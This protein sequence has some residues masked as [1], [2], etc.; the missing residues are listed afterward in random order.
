MSI[1][2]AAHR[3]RAMD[4]TL[5]GPTSLAN[6]R[7]VW[8]GR[9]ISGLAIAFLAFDAAM[10]LVAIAPVVEATT[11]LGYAASDVRPIGAVLMLATLLYALPRTAVLGALLVTAYLGGATATMVHAGQASYFPVVFGVFVWAG[12]VLRRPQLRA[13]LVTPSV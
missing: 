6:N 12:L 5:A 2:R 8:T 3:R 9:I 1:A 11:R 13:I 10:K 4:T 7:L